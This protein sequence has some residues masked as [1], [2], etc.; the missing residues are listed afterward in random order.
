MSDDKY[1]L[2]SAKPAPEKR[3]LLILTGGTEVAKPYQEWKETVDR[4][5]PGKHKK[6]KGLDEGYE[7]ILQY[8]APC[9]DETP[10]EKRHDAWDLP[11]EFCPLC[12]NHQ[13]A[14]DVRKSRG[15]MIINNEYPGL[16]LA[17]GSIVMHYVEDKC[18][19]KYIMGEDP[20]HEDQTE[21]LICDD[22]A[23]TFRA[24]RKRSK[25]LR[26]EERVIAFIHAR[27]M[28]GDRDKIIGSETRK[29]RFAELNERAD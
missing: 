11:P 10:E 7:D 8:D 5:T 16:G 29:E 6:P 12:G 24:D 1:I 17:V 18:M 21:Q 23:P 22:F 9:K 26:I 25:A 14:T 15:P 3:N 2:P 20:E 4:I 19:A 28:A 27:R 13:V